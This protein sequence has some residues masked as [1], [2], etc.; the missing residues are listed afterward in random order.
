LRTWCTRLR[1]RLH[2]PWLTKKYFVKNSF[3]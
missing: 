2:A 1:S 3:H